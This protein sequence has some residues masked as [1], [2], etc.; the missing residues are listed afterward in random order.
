M[1]PAITGIE[2]SFARAPDAK[3]GAGS[4]GEM[5][6]MDPGFCRKT[7]CF[8]VSATVTIVT[9][10]E[11]GMFKGRHF[12]RSVILLCIRWYLAYNL[13]LRNLEEMMAERG[14]SVDHATIHRWTVHYAPLLLAQFN[15]RKRPVS[16][17]WH[18]DETYI[19]V[20]GRWTYL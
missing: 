17:K 6:K 1:V 9:R 14:I 4:A 15:R 8:I 16:R 7:F 18:I 2:A 12:D 20:R 3:M 11:T 10:A 19:K 13:S 5:L